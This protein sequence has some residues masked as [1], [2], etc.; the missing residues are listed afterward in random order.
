MELNDHAKTV[1]LKASSRNGILLCALLLASVATGYGQT[2]G[3][4][5]TQPARCQ[6]TYSFE[7]IYRSAGSAAPPKTRVFPVP[8]KSRPSQK[9][10]TKT[11]F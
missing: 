10:S 7:D 4:P 11:R 6:T 3:E 5:L 1:H 9:K 8:L 2:T